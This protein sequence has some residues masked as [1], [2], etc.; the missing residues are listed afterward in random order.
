MEIKLIQIRIKP[1][2]MKL[3]DGF[4]LFGIISMDDDI[5]EKS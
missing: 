4:M 3:T 1:K 5:G 2:M